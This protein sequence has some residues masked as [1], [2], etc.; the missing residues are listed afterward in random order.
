MT[1]GPSV[2]LSEQGVGS[3]NLQRKGGVPVQANGLSVNLSLQRH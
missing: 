1:W 2:V 3:L